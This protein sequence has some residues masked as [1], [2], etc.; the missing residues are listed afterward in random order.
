MLKDVVDI[1]KNTALRHKA[2]RTFRYQ[3]ND[4]NNA[5]NNHLGYQV[6]LDDVSHHQLNITT[7]IFKVEFQLY[8]LGFVDEN[9]TILDVQNNA[10]TIAADIIAYIDQN[11]AFRGY[12]SVYDYSILV[13][14]RYTDDKSAGVK[15]SL[16][17]AMPSPVNLCELDDNFNEVPY[18]E[19]KDKEID[20]NKEDVGDITINPIK[21]IPDRKC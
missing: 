9:T 12:L 7:G 6:Y 18:E 14:S 16:V 4:L 1:I 19:P 2:V 3:G 10:Y 11:D 5:Q 8:V 13:L 20:V 15:L 17:L 21:L